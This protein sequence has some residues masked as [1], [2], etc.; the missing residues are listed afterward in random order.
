MAQAT[1]TGATT[2]RHALARFITPQTGVTYLMAGLLLNWC[3][4]KQSG[5]ITTFAL[6]PVTTHPVTIAYI[7]MTD[8]ETMTMALDTLQDAYD[9]F[10]SVRNARGLRTIEA[11][12]VATSRHMDNITLLEHENRLLR[13]RNERLEAELELAHA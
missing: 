3:A 13:A 5:L 9:S 10:C 4:L 12:R 7:K 8:L 2:T 11:L 1:V 6:Q